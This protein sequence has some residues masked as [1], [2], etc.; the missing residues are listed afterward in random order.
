MSV[1]GGNLLLAAS[2]VLAILLGLPLDVNPKHSL[3]VAACL[4]LSS[5]PLAVKFIDG[6]L[7]GWDIFRLDLRTRLLC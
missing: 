1:Y 6:E 2:I 4:F 5:S 7:G 3:F